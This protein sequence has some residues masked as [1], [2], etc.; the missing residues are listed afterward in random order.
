MMMLRLV[1]A[2]IL[3]FVA[4]NCLQVFEESNA[5]RIPRDE[6]KAL[7]A[8]SDKLENVNWKVTERYCIEDGGFNGKI[9]ID[10]DIFG[11]DS[12]LKGQNIS[13]VFPSEFGNLTQL[14]ELDLT[15]NYLSGSLPT[16][17]SPNSL[18]VLSLL[19]NRLS[20][21]IPTE[22]GDIAS[23]EELVLECNQLEGPLPP[24]FGN[25]SKLKRLLLSANNF[26][27]TIPETYS[28]LKNLTEFRIDGSSLSGPIP[29]FIGNWTNLIRLDLQGTNMEG[30]IPP[31]ISQ[32][33]LLTE[34]R[35]TDLNGGPSMTFPD[36]KN[37]TKLK[38]LE[39][40]NCLITGSIPGYIGEMANLATLDLS[41][42]ML[43]GS[44]PDSI[45]K[46]DNLDYLDLSYNNFTNS[47]AT[48]CQLLDVNLA[49]SHFSSAVTSAS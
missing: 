1:Y 30:P 11:D 20:G 17:F 12:F 37:L 36:L 24:S 31:T 41:F 33:K 14:K 43:T 19:G 49:S 42:N 46:L 39:L 27:G 35:I 16:N 5:Q 26:T 23:L 10:N 9:N 40:R 47:S 32:L 2:L 7:Q 48:S 45:Q 15:R 29:S 34:L 21:R 25:L 3:G 44:V 22:I 18:V 28:K 38:R 4:L 13:G 8:I 6:V